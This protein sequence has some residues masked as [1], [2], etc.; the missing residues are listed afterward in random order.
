MPEHTQE[1][2]S[3]S[4]YWKAELPRAF[5]TDEEEERALQG[6][7][8]SAARSWNAGDRVLDIGCGNGALAVTLAALAREYGKAFSYTGLDQAEILQPPDADFE[9]LDVVLLGNTRAEIAELRD[10]GFE[11]V[12]SQYGF[13]Y[14]DREAVSTN[15]A[16]WLVPEGTVTF[17]VHSQDSHVT[18]EV[19]YTLE[20][21]R[22][23]EESALLILVARLLSRLVDLGG[24]ENADRQAEAMRDL[25]NTI[26]Q[27]LT[28]KAEHMPN[29]HVL[30]NFVGVCLGS[31]ASR[32]SHI[33]LDVRLENIVSFSKQLQFQKDRLMQQQRAALSD[34]QIDESIAYL[35]R[36]GLSCSRR[37]ALLYN[38]E[39]FGFGLEFVKR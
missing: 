14:C 29:P 39:R 32:R 8:R 23:A 35:E 3:W 15:V 38:E 34:R 5:G 13:E 12:I 10:S 9:P 2:S 27:E 7:W 1:A 21:L 26:C 25:V 16:A 36:S 17:L 18:A 19:R 24:A 4:N 22:M 28:D 30:R 33:P 6:F 11:R 37:K 31:F 20:Q